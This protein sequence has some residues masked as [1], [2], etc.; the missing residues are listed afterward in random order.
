MGYIIYIILFLLCSLCNN[1]NAQPLY[2]NYYINPLG[3]WSSL[4]GGAIM[5][6]DTTYIAGI[7]GGLGYAEKSIIFGKLNSE[8]E[9]VFMKTY[10][11]Q[12]CRYYPGFNGCFRTIDDQNFIFIISKR[13]MITNFNSS[14]L[15]Y[16]NHN[17]D[18]LFS[19]EFAIAEGVGTIARQTIPAFDDGYYVIGMHSPLNDTTEN[20]SFFILKTD[21]V[22]NI[23]W[24]QSY[25]ITWQN[26]AL[27]MVKTPDNGLL[28]SGFTRDQPAAYSV[29]PLVVKADSLGNILWIW[30]EGSIYDDTKAVV[31][32]ADDG[33]Y[34][35]AYTHAVYQGPPY[36][37]PPARKILRVVKFDPDGEIIW[38]KD[39]GPETDID[40]YVNYLHSYDDGAHLI[41][42]RQ[43]DDSVLR[44]TSYILK[45][46]DD[47]DSLWMRYYEHEDA[48]GIATMNV[49]SYLNVTPGNSILATGVIVQYG[50][51]GGVQAMWI[52]H[53]DSLGCVEKDCDPTVGLPLAFNQNST[54]LFV[55][56]NPASN[57]CYIRIPEE[58][59]KT[60]RT[61]F[62]INLFNS[63]GVLV[64]QIRRKNSDE[65]ISLDTGHLPPG[66]YLLQLTDGLS[67]SGQTKL[68][69][70]R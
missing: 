42:G 52:M 10:G 57:I 14:I 16:L 1:L 56:P 2:S 17:F 66:L 54:G 20:S 49:I 63:Q 60:G 12:Y 61:H 28:I 29:K 65:I 32:I 36:P 22:F 59:G 55:Y 68:L 15:Y 19:K 24:Q 33:N 27:Y 45:I 9:M 30:N 4:N 69:I 7:G 3:T 50:V 25:S 38:E 40:Y 5:M 70:H 43:W 37:I 53:L 11:E 23:E 48:T 51:P 46:N 39:Y 58:M 62:H 21:S 13:N 8:G 64:Q 18:T 34:L 44:W 41:G 26:E 6:N 31:S 35:A 47:G 67:I